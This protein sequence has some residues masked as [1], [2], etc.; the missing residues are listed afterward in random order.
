MACSSGFRN[1]PWACSASGSCSDSPGCAA[2]P[3]HAAKPAT[4]IFIVI[5]LRAVTGIGRG[6]RLA[7]AKVV[8]KRSLV[9]R[10]AH[11]HQ[12]VRAGEANFGRVAGGAGLVAVD[13]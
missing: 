9:D 7:V 4:F 8:G 5:Q 1:G 13:G 12:V 10:A 11:I 6:R 3:E 2:I